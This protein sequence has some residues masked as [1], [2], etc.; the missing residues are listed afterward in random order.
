VSVKRLLLDSGLLDQDR[1]IGTGTVV[2]NNRAV[3]D[4]NIIAGTGYDASLGYNENV[5]FYDGAKLIYDFAES[6]M[7]GI[8]ATVQSTP[9]VQV[10]ATAS[11][12]DI[13]SSGQA[14]VRHF[15][16]GASNLG[17]LSATATTIPV[18]L[19]I[20]EASLGELVSTAFA[21]VE[22]VEPIVPT[23]G[24]GGPRRYKQVK[25]KKI[26]PIIEIVPN[27]EV[28]NLEPLEPLVK[29]IFA[30]TFFVPPVFMGMAQSQI[31]FSTE[32]DDLDLLLIL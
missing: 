16:D 19:P 2:L 1:I 21:T 7:G 27:L 8:S 12:G 6:I 22:P 10:T 29:T 15:V 28:I 32:Q 20:F 3:L 17:S 11:L 26:E 25:T 14:N 9:T 5:N 13:T 23:G 24:G 18:I 4:S 31:D 30:K